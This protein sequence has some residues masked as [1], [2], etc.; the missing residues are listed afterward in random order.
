MA[1]PSLNFSGAAGSYV[2]IGS[3]S[4]FLTNNG[5]VAAWIRTSDA[6]SGFR[7][8]VVKPNTFGLF[9]LDNVLVTYDWSA[10]GG[11]SSTGINL[12]DGQYHHVAMVFRKACRRSSTLMVTRF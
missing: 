1:T 11:T 6:G 3:T 2:A 4:D 8:I 5:T 12:A 7:G 10:S 9:L